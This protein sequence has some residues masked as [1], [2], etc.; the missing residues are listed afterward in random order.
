MHV[1]PGSGAPRTGRRRVVFTKT[2]LRLAL[3]FGLI[4]CDFAAIRIGFELGVAV[5]GQKWLSPNGVEV[6]WLI[7]GLHLL[8]GLRRGAYSTGTLTSRTESV[9]LGTSTFLI[10]TG[11]VALLIFFQYAG[12]LVSRLAFGVA[13]IAS[14]F[15][16]AVGRLLFLTFFLPRDKS[17]LVGELVIFDGA[18]PDLPAQTVIDARRE[19]IQPTLTDPHML[20]ELAET[21]AAY[22]RVIVSTHSEN[23]P[24]WAMALKSF[25]VTGEVMLDAEDR[26]GVIGVDRYRGRETLV[27]S[28]GPLSLANRLKKRMTDIIISALC[29]IA[30]GP[31][32]LLVA[33]AIKLDSRGPVF[34][35]QVRV[36]RGNR[37]FRI[38]KFRSMYAERTDQ[39]GARSAT[40]DDERVTRIGRLIRATS[41]DELPQ[42]LNVLRGDMSMVGPRPHALGSLAGEKLFWEVTERYWLRHT[43]K[44]GI[45][46]LAQVRGYRGAT[47]RQDDLENR[48]QS[49]LEY[50]NGWSMWRDIAIL[51]RTALVLVHPRAY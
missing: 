30:L 41:I 51:L 2:H 38:L 3:Y 29:L 32:M 43:L 50:V 13:I 1:S 27:V 15:F 33:L 7:C 49:D 34:F 31:L 39:D 10:A 48:L 16:I 9:R 17:Q 18:N 45:T 12:A 20:A 46:G 44:P 23:A 28:R 25:N 21:V 5:R 47:H 26:L 35:R 8:L 11:T 37:M 36:G 22:D 24:D 40:Q 14:L 6:G 42:L 4:V 19:G